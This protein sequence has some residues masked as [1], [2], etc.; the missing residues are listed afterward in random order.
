[1][2]LP[3]RLAI[4]RRR[5]PGRPG[6]DEQDLVMPRD[7]RDFFHRKYDARFIVRPHGGDDCG[8]RG[9]SALQ[10]LQVEVPFGVNAN[11]A[12]HA[13]S[14]RESIAMAPCRAVF[15]CGRNDVLSSR[16]K[17]QG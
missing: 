11:H 2:S 10:F 17:L 14:F 3:F 16:I 7:R 12:H 8:L 1:M 13:T 5:Q 4:R 15:D 9:D 6:A